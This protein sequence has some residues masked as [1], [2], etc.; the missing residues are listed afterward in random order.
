MPF[1]SRVPKDMAK[2]VAFRKYILDLAETSLDYQQQLFIACKRDILFFANTFLWVYE[3]RQSMVYPFITYPF[4]DRTIAVMSRDIGKRDMG[5]EK[6]RDMGATWVF[7][8]VFFHEWIFKKRRAFGLVSRTEDL[9]DKRDDPDTLMWKIDFHLLNLPGWM[10]PPVNRGKLSLK[11]LSTN[12]TIT[13]YSATAD[14]G[15]GGRKTAF[16][17]DEMAAFRID[18]GYAVW[19]STQHVTDCRIAVSTPKG[20]A[21]VFADTLSNKQ[22]EMT[23]ISMHWS[24]HP[25]KKLGLYQSIDDHVQII[26][27]EYDFPEDYGFIKDGK[28]RSPW[29]DE[30]CRRHPVPQFIAQELDIDYGGS[31]FPFFNGTVI[32]R[33]MR[34]YVTDPF[35]RG[36]L[37]F[38]T[39]D[40]DTTWLANPAGRLLLWT[41]L[42]IDELPVKDQDYVI[43]C[44]VATGSGG[45]FT[46]NSVASVALKTTGEKVAE[47]SVND[48]APHE[49]A[50]YVIAL[51]KFFMGPSGEAYVIWE[52]NGPGVQFRKHFLA[53]SNH[54][55]YFRQNEKSVYQKRSAMPGFWSTKE[56]KR[57]LLGEY[58]KGLESGKFINHSGP[59]LEEMTHYI[60]LPTGAIEHDKSQAT[61][62]P[63]AAGEN[64]GDR[65]IAD[66]LCYKGCESSPAGLKENNTIDAPVG[67]MAWRFEQAKAD[68][69]KRKRNEWL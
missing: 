55:I 32:E 52:D 45:D 63:T 69:F 68:S 43:G 31:G 5:I 4:Q 46:T 56:T 9:V 26:D 22:S 18:D 25:Q 37:I 29:Y 64:H 50:D 30:Q 40:Y 48:L 7:L 19:A 23:K 35:T 34:D 66:A 3:P 60:H 21:G 10:V 62:D 2:N 41:H 15:R 65:V 36:E 39:E 42:T 59:A 13:G 58:G 61:L 20:L 28:L 11:N 17:M 38:N 14:V 47:L 24:E 6:S 27:E 1:Y 33:H 51:R 12:S 8:S 54:R 49:F 67:S 57:T 44:D 53:K 16:G